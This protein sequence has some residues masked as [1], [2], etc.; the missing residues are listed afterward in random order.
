M[1]DDRCC[2]AHC[3]HNIQ[4]KVSER[5]MVEKGKKKARKNAATEVR[6]YLALVLTLVSSARQDELDDKYCLFHRLSSG[7]PEALAILVSV[8][9]FRF[10]RSIEKVSTAGK[11]ASTA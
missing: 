10:E 6:M 1:E 5:Q 7:L 4:Y 9:I 3:I 8:S 2:P 11:Q